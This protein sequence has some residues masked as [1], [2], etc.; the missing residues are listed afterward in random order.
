MALQKVQ[1]TTILRQVVVAIG[2]ASSR[3]GVLASF[4][5]TSLHNLLH[6]IGDGFRFE[7]S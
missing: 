1:A 4:L 5:P 3:L 6:A 2:E 7:V